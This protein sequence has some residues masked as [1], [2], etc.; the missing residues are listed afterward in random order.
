MSRQR[1]EQ[2]FY[3]RSVATKRKPSIGLGLGGGLHEVCAAQLA[4]VGVGE[5]SIQSWIGSC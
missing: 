1:V 5:P 2:S 4:V 3:D